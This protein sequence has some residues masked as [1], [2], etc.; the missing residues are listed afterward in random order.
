MGRD[1]RA[2]ASPAAMARTAAPRLMGTVAKSGNRAAVHGSR[3]PVSKPVED[4]DEKTKKEI[5]EK[6]R[7][8][9]DVEKVV[10]SK[11]NKD[12]DKD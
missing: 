11:L 12:N 6:Q 3:P 2:L 7:K 8:R 4:L 5:D 10:N 9:E 1:L